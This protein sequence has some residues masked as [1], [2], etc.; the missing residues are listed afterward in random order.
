M[1][2]YLNQR[3]HLILREDLLTKMLSEVELCTPSGK[4]MKIFFNQ[5]NSTSNYQLCFENYLE[6]MRK[7]GTWASDIEIVG[8]QLLYGIQIV[9]IANLTQ[10]FGAFDTAHFVSDGDKSA[11]TIFLY[12]HLFSLPEIPASQ[13][14]INHFM[15][16]EPCE[17]EQG[18]YKDPY[19]GV[20][21]PE[22]R[23]VVD[24]TENEKPDTSHCTSTS[25]RE[26]TIDSWTI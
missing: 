6:K 19:C 4:T 15:Y 1:S 22:D 16:L 21:K 24:M 23:R 5:R 11:C 17:C 25:K 13:Q 8:F 14:H 12:C 7:P 2:P 10:G 26:K 9:S 3:D 18:L 20:M